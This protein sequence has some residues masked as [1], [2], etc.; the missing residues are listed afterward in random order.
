MAE[1]NTEK[2]KMPKGGRKGGSRFPQVNLAKAL[3]YSKKLVA[4]T[5]IGPLPASTILPGVFQNS[6]GIGNVRASALRQYGLLEG[7]A[8]AYQATKLAKQIDASPES[9]KTALLQQ[10][11]LLPK[12]FNE[13]HQTFRGDT[14]SRAKI[15]QRARG[16]EVHPE[17]A[18]E[19][20]Q[21]F[22]ESLIT[23]GLGTIDGENVSLSST[24][25]L[26]SD[27]SPDQDQNDAVLEGTDEQQNIEVED[28]SDQ[29][30]TRDA[31]A[32]DSK[33]K[34]PATTPNG[35]PRPSIAVNIDVDSSSDPEKLEKQL[36]LLR[37]FGL[38]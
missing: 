2:K 24:G 3:E 20:T 23:A 30:E 11:F 37:S 18:T 27:A 21:L 26:N 1:A 8:A 7:P 36:K 5:H 32:A 34:P 17:S 31:A 35:S 38:V 12:I 4:K 22:I 25:R 14:V 9:E 6:G 10:A 33:A 29:E 28:S 19:C 16:L 15:E 13:I